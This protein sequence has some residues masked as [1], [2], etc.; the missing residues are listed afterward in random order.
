MKIYKD[1]IIYTNG[2]REIIL[3]FTEEE[4]LNDT[5]KIQDIMFKHCI[6]TSSYPVGNLR[7]D[8][9]EHI[10]DNKYRYVFYGNKKDI[11]NFQ[12]VKDRSSKIYKLK[13]HNFDKPKNVNIIITDFDRY[14]YLLEEYDEYFKYSKKYNI[15]NILDKVFFEESYANSLLYIM[16]K[17][18]KNENDIKNKEN[19]KNLIFHF[20]MNDNHGYDYWFAFYL[21]YE[22]NLLEDYLDINGQYFISTIIKNAKFLSRQILIML[23]INLTLKSNKLINLIIE[24][25][26]N[27][28]E[29]IRLINTYLYIFDD[30][31]LYLL[32]KYDISNYD[33]ISPHFISIVTHYFIKTYLIKNKNDRKNTFYKLLDTINN[34]Q[35]NNRTQYIFIFDVLSNVFFKDI[36]DNRFS[37]AFDELY[38]NIMEMNAYN[39][40]NRIHMIMQW[41]I[42]TLL[43]FNKEE[44][45]YNDDRLL[46]YYLSD[47][48]KVNDKI[49]SICITKTSNM[50]PPIIKHFK[51]KGESVIIKYSNINNDDNTMINVISYGIKTNKGIKYYYLF[52][53]GDVDMINML[54][55]KDLDKK[56]YRF[57]EDNCIITTSQDNI[58]NYFVITGHNSINNVTYSNNYITKYSLR[59]S[60]YENL[61]IIFKDNEF[62]K[63]INKFN[64]ITY[65]DIIYTKRCDI[66][67]CTDLI[68]KYNS[69]ISFDIYTVPINE[70]TNE[71]YINFLNWIMNTYARIHKIY[72]SEKSFS[73]INFSILTKSTID[74]YV[75]FIH[76]VYIPDYNFPIQFTSITLDKIFFEEYDDIKIIHELLYYH[77]KTTYKFT[78]IENNGEVSYNSI[79]LIMYL[80]LSHRNCYDL[81]Q[82][83]L[84]RDIPSKVKDYI[85]IQMK[86]FKLIQ[87]ININLINYTY[88]F[89]AVRHIL[90]ELSNN[91][92]EVENELSSLL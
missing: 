17:N 70:F 81:S 47:N 78:E 41:L 92:E 84:K 82:E 56:I 87:Y 77:K 14:Q 5:P 10:N 52:D 38:V 11:M 71:K 76:D 30:I 88:H 64:D 28:M 18:Y 35:M 26:N 73:K 46:S 85:N 80:I 20:L 4:M 83:L 49:L 33:G 2:K 40:F 62:L 44:L 39:Q 63:G 65:K 22:N 67:Q 42:Y 57:N 13:K 91:L 58:K 61:E 72:K 29:Y 50:T 60:Y 79:I 45:I 89:S 1:E 37:Y 66:D 55:N 32:S 27:T 15:L 8:V 90:T 25:L 68:D 12:L 75:N 16:F 24:N 23:K 31:N 36:Y 19:I 54:C 86:L 6:S 3:E 48:T 43:H 53:L 7:Y 9:Y 69:N 51:N 59:E 74:K 34:I 21:L